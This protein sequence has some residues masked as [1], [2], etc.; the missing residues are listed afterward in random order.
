[1]P[2]TLHEKWGCHNDSF[3][4]HDI[5]GASSLMPCLYCLHFFEGHYSTFE[6]HNCSTNS[7]SH[8]K[9]KVF[10]SV[11][12]LAAAA[13]EFSGLIASNRPLLTQSVA[14]TFISRPLVVRRPSFPTS[15]SEQLSTREGI[16][17]HRTRHNAT[18][19]PP[20]CSR[21][22][23]H[24]ILFRSQTSQLSS[25]Y[26]HGGIQSAHYWRRWK[27]ELCRR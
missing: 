7:G 10:Q 3:M 26:R 24:R 5:L 23:F 21:R 27:P 17:G 12:L 19:F 13:G 22:R 15:T 11:S 8:D 14:L 25:S 1:M 16:C 4:T 2:Y 6:N 18:P 9:M 20:Q